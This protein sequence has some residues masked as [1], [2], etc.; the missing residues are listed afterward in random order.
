M[1]YPKYNSTVS[2][3]YDYYEFISIGH[4]GE[5]LKG[6]LFH[7]TTVNPFFYNCVLGDVK[8]D[9]RID[10]YVVTNN[11]DME[12]VLA[13]VAAAAFEFSF[14]YPDCYIVLKGAMKSVH[15]YTEWL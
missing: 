2:F 9:G 1:Q 11:G 8:E 3:A 4:K 15:D 12:K 13:T 5:I 7:Q 6:I 14:Q 10:A